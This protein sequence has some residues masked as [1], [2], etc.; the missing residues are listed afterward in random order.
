MP[1]GN[2]IDEYRSAGENIRWY[3]NIRFAQLTLF[4]ALTALILNRLFPADSSFPPPYELGLKLIGAVS[5]IVFGYMELRADEYWTH[6]M[7]RAEILEQELG[8]C[9]YTTRPIRRVRTTHLLR[10]FFLGVFAFWVF[11]MFVR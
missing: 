7:R 1:Q 11:T 9:Q 10:A 3:S 5:A 6:F 8:F 2:P 4:V